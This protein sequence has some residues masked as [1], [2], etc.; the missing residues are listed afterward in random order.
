[1]YENTETKFKA[2][3]KALILLNLIYNNI[4]DLETEYEMDQQRKNLEASSTKM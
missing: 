4:I 2:L 3:T 1:M